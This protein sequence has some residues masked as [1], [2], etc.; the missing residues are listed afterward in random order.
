MR[1]LKRSWMVSES[2]SYFDGTELMLA[3]MLWDPLN[4]KMKLTFSRVLDVSENTHQ[5]DHKSIFFV[6]VDHANPQIFERTFSDVAR[7][8]RSDMDL[9]YT[10]TSVLGITGLSVSDASNNSPIDTP[11]ELLEVIESTEKPFFWLR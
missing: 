5:E 8:V 6:I 3:D 1:L 7:D 9:Q 2:A 4:M 11:E 10:I